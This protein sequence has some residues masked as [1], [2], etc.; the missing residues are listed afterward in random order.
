MLAARRDKITAAGVGELAAMSPPPGWDGGPVTPATAAAFR[1]ALT[2]LVD[3]KIAARQAQADAAAAALGPHARSYLR[4]ARPWRAF[5]A[6][7][8]SRAAAAGVA[9]L[10]AMSPPRGRDGGPVTA[11]N[12]EAFRAARLD[13]LTRQITRLDARITAA[14]D[15]AG[16]VT[17]NHATPAGT[18]QPAPRARRRRRPPRRCPGTSGPARA[19]RA[20]GAC[21]R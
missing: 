13:R 3:A 21:G 12:A 17:G 7:E 15:L 6:A 14:A 5:L 4:A 8:R 2:G 11:A 19:G 10:A 9:E 1:H 20:G 16:A 18:G